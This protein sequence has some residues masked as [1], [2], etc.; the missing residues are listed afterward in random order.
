MRNEIESQNENDL[1]ADRLKAKIR[2]FTEH[3]AIVALEKRRMIASLPQPHFPSK[4][5]MESKSAALVDLTST[6]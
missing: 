6:R 5:V 2:I 3:Q 4:T 1:F